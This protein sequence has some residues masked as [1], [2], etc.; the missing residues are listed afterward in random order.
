MTDTLWSDVSEFNPPVNDSYPYGLLSFRSNDGTY[1]DSVFHQNLSWSLDALARGKLWAMMVYYFFRPSSDGAAVLRQRV[2]TPHPRMV[3]MIDVETD[4]GRVSGDQSAVINKQFDELANWLGDDRR[5]I[6]YGNVGDLN[7]LWPSKPL[8]IRLIIAAYGS[9]PGYPGKFAHQFTDNANVPP[10]GPSDL[11][12]ADG[13]DRNA[14]ETMFGFNSP[15]PVPTWEENLV[16]SLPELTQGATGTY[17]RRVQGLCVA[18]GHNVAIDGAFGPGTRAA[19]EAVQ[20]AAHVAVDGIVGPQ[21]WAAL[22][23]GAGL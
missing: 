7:A 4:G 15:V 21:T 1:L 23:T 13:M 14:L 3:A 8:G 10:F 18:D 5:V 2:G 20:S 17:V 11:N 22:L 9:N 6:G 16:K 12:S 19:V